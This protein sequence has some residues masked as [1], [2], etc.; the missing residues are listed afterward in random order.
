[1]VCVGPVGQSDKAVPLEKKGM[2][3]AAEGPVFSIVGLLPPHLIV[4][5]LLEPA[6]ASD[7][8]HSI[9]LLLLLPSC[10]NMYFSCSSAHTQSF[11]SVLLHLAMVLL[12]AK[13]CWQTTGVT[14]EHGT[15]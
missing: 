2:L 8:T 14:C 7:W 15:K 3:K 11:F 5:R 13:L 4:A 1:M 9:R 10:C 12:C 6:H